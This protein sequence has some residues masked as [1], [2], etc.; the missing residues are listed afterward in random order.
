MLFFQRDIVSLSLVRTN[1]WWKE[2]NRRLARGLVPH[3][4]RTKKS[5]F[6]LCYLLRAAICKFVS[7]ACK[8]TCKKV[9]ILRQIARQ[10]HRTQSFVPWRNAAPTPHSHARTK[11]HC[12]C[13]C[14]KNAPNVYFSLLLQEGTLQIL[15]SIWFP[16][17][18]FLFMTLA[19]NRS[20]FSPQLEPES[21]FF[22]VGLLGNHDSSKKHR[23]SPPLKPTKLCLSFPFWRC[24][25]VVKFQQ[26][27]GQTQPTPSLCFKTFY[28]TGPLQLTAL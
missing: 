16:R 13:A 17:V 9:V 12:T 7:G 2:D 1:G 28:I 24:G 4:V 15:N 8:C 19:W 22:D 23:L 25:T 3:L 5:W 27:C 18:R 10:I 20:R 6:V 11:S 26:L 14:A 21:C